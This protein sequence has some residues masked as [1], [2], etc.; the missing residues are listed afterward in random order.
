MELSIQEELTEAGKGER[1]FNRIL[2]LFLYVCMIKTQGRKK[3]YE[4]SITTFTIIT[5]YESSLLWYRQTY[6]EMNKKGLFSLHI[7]GVFV[8]QQRRESVEF[9]MVRSRKNIIEEL[10]DSHWVL[11]MLHNYKLA[12]FTSVI[13]LL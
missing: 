9:A 1:S 3:K 13:C 6:G 12:D 10:P 5:L 4:K 11:G 7:S 8:F 2:N